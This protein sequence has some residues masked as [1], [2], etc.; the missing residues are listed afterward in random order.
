MIVKMVKAPDSKQDSLPQNRSPSPQ[1]GRRTRPAGWRRAAGQQLKKCNIRH[2]KNIKYLYHM[3][4]IFVK[5][6]TALGF[7]LIFGYFWMFHCQRPSALYDWKLTRFF[8]HGCIYYKHACGT[9]LVSSF[10]W[11]WLGENMC[12]LKC[13]IHI[14]RVIFLIDPPCSV[15]KW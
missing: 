4:C 12:T 13:S 5:E 9:F 8:S 1:P 6:E 7:I 10:L 2:K 11:D 15:P 14:Y 3:K